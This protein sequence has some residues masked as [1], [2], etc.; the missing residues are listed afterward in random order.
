MRVLLSL[1]DQEDM[2]LIGEDFL[3]RVKTPRDC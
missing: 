1:S 3:I 2:T